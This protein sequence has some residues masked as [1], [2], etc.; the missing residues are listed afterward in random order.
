MAAG[1]AQHYLDMGGYANHKPIITDGLA[2]YVDAGNGLSYSGSGTTW[3]DLIDGNTNLSSN[4]PTYNSSN[5]GYF[6]YD[7]NNDS[8]DWSANQTYTGTLTVSIWAKWPTTTAAYTPMFSTGIDGL[9]A[10]EAG[11]LQFGRSSGSANTAFSVTVAGAPN[12]TEDVTVSSS[13]FNKWTNWVVVAKSGNYKVYADGNLLL[14]SGSGNNPTFSPTYKFKI[15]ENRNDSVWAEMDAACAM[16][17]TKE[18]SS[19]EI[20]QNYNALKNRFI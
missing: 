12:V 18:L 4:Y 9:S 10:N 14:N 2:L 6:S 1:R 16:I 19:T 17:H 5:G 13:Y 15:A 11:S 20:T 3:T 8:H 7:G